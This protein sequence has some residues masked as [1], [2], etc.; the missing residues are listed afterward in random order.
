MPVSE[1]V[2]AY[3][4]GRI[5]VLETRLLDKSKLERMVEAP[6]VDEALKVLA[7][8][9][10]ANMV[11]EL[12]SVYEFEKILQE[13]IRRT[14][15]LVQKINP[16]AHLTDLI[17][18]KYDLHNLKVL[19]KAKYLNE[20]GDTLL[21]PVGTIPLDKLRAIVAEENFQELPAALRA[22][23]EQIMEEFVVSGDPQIIDLSLD[24]T[25]YAMLI[26]AARELR[27]TVLEGLFVREA[28]LTNI[29]TF[30]RVKRM[31]RDKEF[32]KK[33]FLPH[34]RLPADLFINLL[35]EPLEFLADRLA[36]SD[37][38]AVVSEGVRE[39]QEKGNITNFEKLAD[40]LLTAYL[41]Q[42]KRKPFGLDPLV[43][44][45]HA[46]EIEIKNIRAILVGKINGLP[47][48]AIRERLRNVYV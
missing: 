23:V 38:A 7:E 39:W 16:E 43:G 34:G 35:D 12:D 2:Y 3:A 30:L 42:G 27:S 25:L 31:G 22:A 47:I 28:D 20:D 44:Y 45:L 24:R 21:F 26:S 4:V 14:Y 10:Y 33:A 46:K 15:Q 5:R 1:T 6:T 29:K 18:L 9:D 41:Q 32:L 11:A 48:E 19:L 37:Y 8:T 40:D 36:M 17:S 13:E